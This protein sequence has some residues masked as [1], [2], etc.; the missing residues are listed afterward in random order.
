M[1][2]PIIY[3]K[4]PIVMRQLELIVGT[5]RFRDGLREYL[6]RARG[7]A[8]WLDLVRILDDRTSE[9]IEWSRAWVEERGRPEF[10]TSVQLSARADWTRS[11]TQRDPQNRGLI[12]PQRLRVI[13]GFDDSVKELPVYLTQATTS[14][15]GAQGLPAPRR[16]PGRRRAWYGLFTLDEEAATI[17]CSTSRTS[18]TR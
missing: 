6:K 2:G 4:A 7:N 15:K 16:A 3:Q 8:T 1:Y 11:I 17:C 14:V 9:N 18:R 10:T 5:R 12:W 13:V